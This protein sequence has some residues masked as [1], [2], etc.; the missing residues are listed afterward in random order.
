MNIIYLYLTIIV[1]VIAFLGFK[2]LTKRRQ[3]K[4]AYEERE[5]NVFYDTVK[6]IR[7]D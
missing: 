1:V 3:E 7:R 2:I 6:N 4:Q 5:E